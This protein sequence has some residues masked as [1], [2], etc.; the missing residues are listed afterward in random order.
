VPVNHS[1]SNGSGGE[2]SLADR[3]YYA[4]RDLILRGRLPMGAVVSRRRLAE[5]L[6]MSM[7]PVSDAVQRLETEGLLESKPQ[8]GTRVRIPTELDV[9]ERFIIREMLESQA[10][11]MFVERATFEQR[12][13]LKQMAGQMDTLFSRLAAAGDDAEFVYAVHS[14]HSQL[15]MRIAEYSGCRALRE[16]VQKNNVLVLN[17][18]YDLAGKQP[19]PPRF[20]EQLAEVLSGNDP[21]AADKAMRAHVRQGVEETVGAINALESAVNRRW[22]LGRASVQDVR[23]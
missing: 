1:Q 2:V 14:Y 15:H 7:F 9:R 3:A 10:A 5:E 16:M 12:L 19:V 6:R 18:L 8:V 11:R 23:P 21:D 22:R 4:I 13:E 20:H 17:W